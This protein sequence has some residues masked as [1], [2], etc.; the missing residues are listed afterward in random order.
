MELRWLEYAYEV[1]RQGSFTK[2]A[3]RLRV[4]Q[5]SLSQQV[6]KLERELGA[7]LFVRGHAAAVPTDQGR[8]L[9]SYAEQMLRLRDDLLREVAEASGGMNRTLAIGTL[10]ITGGHVLPPLLQAF[11]A[12]HP[13]V[14]VRIV[15]E[16]TECLEEL[17]AAGE[18]DLSI[19]AL[20][21]DDQRLETRP[22]L[23]EP[24]YLA[25]P[26]ER[27]GRAW[28]VS[29]ALP[30][31]PTIDG[32]LSSYADAPFI[33]LKSGFGFRGT[34]LA[35]CAEYGFS[36]RI[37]YETSSVETAQTMVA[38]GLGVTVVPAMVRRFTAPMPVYI[39]LGSSTTRTLVFAFRKDRYLSLAAQAFLNVWLDV[40]KRS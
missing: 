19:L 33:M 28:E 14:Q 20:P 40:A 23:T 35:L 26:P 6:A 30:S 4:A 13:D 29:S 22:M 25:V 32:P 2:A 9:L 24:L 27:D 18:T 31:Q 17:T 8:R 34:V 10:A 36:P 39:E 7:R 37:A 38:H 5:P 12:K 11:A 3:G 15:E 21:V 1:Y 16:T